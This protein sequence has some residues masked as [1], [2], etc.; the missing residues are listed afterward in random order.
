MNPTVQPPTMPAEATPFALVQA[1]G[2]PALAEAWKGCFETGRA[3][4]YAQGIVTASM[5]SLAIVVA[6][7]FIVVLTKE[8]RRP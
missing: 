5:V 6:V 2:R 7:L 8:T 1:L 3:A 4:G